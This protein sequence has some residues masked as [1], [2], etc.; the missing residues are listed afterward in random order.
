[1]SFGLLAVI[2]ELMRLGSVDAPLKRNQEND[3]NQL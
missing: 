3:Y 1:V 2:G